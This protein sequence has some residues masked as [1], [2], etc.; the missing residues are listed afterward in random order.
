MKNIP[1]PQD[2]K[3]IKLCIELSKESLESGGAPFGAL[4]VKDD[5][6]IAKSI[7]NAQNRVSDHAEIVVMDKAHKRLKSP[8]L[9]SCTL[10]SNCEPCPMC[11]FMIREYR[12]KKVVFALPS[13]YMGG[14]SKWNILEDKKLTEF[15]L[16]F[17]KPPEIISGVFEKEAKKVYENT[18]LWMFGSN[19]QKPLKSKNDSKN[20]N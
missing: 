8:D 15:D 14:L 5:K 3:L 18:P 6:I 19:P 20:K 11:S 2:K 4:V 7:N 13:I 9:S 12:I 1:T 17:G 16:F 10:Y